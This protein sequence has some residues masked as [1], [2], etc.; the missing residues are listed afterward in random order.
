[1]TGAYKK[2]RVATVLEGEEPTVD[3]GRMLLLHPL[4]T[5]ACRTDLADYHSDST[6]ALDCLGCDT[7]MFVAKYNDKNGTYSKGGRT[8]A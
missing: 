4:H 1:M 3:D 5:T 8:R 2:K 6:L 7:P